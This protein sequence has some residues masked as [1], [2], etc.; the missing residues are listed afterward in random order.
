[1][2]A[3][4]KGLWSNFSG[5][6]FTIYFCIRET[7]SDCLDEGARMSFVCAFFPHR[8]WFDPVQFFLHSFVQK[9]QMIKN[10]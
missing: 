8:T 10:F 4:Y 5:L 6:G 9:L 3:P 2:L 1:M 7:I